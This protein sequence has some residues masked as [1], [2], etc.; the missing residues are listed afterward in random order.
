AVFERGAVDGGEIAVI[1]LVLAGKDAHF[2][3]AF[4]LDAFKKA[5]LVAG[6]TD[7]AGTD[8]DHVVDA[9]RL[10]ESRVNLGNPRGTIHRGRAQYVKFRHAFADADGFA[11]FIGDFE[12]E[13]GDIFH[14]D[15]A[16]T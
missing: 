2:D 7:R 11:Y 9:R 16:P 1:R 3:A 12:A 15:Q 4:T 5:F 14:H 10:T 8:G 6:V 13:L